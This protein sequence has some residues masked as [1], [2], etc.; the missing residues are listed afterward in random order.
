MPN[1]IIKKSIKRSPEIDKLSWFEEVVFY[2]LILTADDFGRLDGRTVLLKNDLFPTKDTIT[3]KAVEDAIG[4]LASV[5]L[6]T[7]YVDEES[8]MSYYY[9]TTW[10]K[11]QRIRDSKKKF[12]DPPQVA[13]NCGELPQVAA[14]CGLE[15]ESKSESKSE[16]N[17]DT[18]LPPYTGEDGRLSAVATYA[19]KISFTP[20][21]ASMRELAEYE[22]ELGYDVCSL[23]MDA[24]LDAGARNWNYVK[25]ILNNCAQNGIT[26]REA[27]NQHQE[28]RKSEGRIAHGTGWAG[29]PWQHTEQD[30]HIEP[31]VKA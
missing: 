22:K 20:S 4:K 3:R 27:W 18:P 1:R 5:G 21:T 17:D 19:K 10:H 11:H 14:N 12:P 26:S 7:P 8:G 16:S 9:F 13:A 15:S 23:A 2:R 24:A 25:A 29:K 31:A 6:L 30:Y 28:S